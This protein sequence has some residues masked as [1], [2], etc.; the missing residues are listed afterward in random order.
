MYEEF[1]TTTCRYVVKT[2]DLQVISYCFILLPSPSTL[3]DIFDI[4]PFVYVYIVFYLIDNFA[5]I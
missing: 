5:K 3:P 1:S 4:C 2:F